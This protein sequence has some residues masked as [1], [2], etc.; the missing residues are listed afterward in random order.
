MQKDL[1]WLDLSTQSDFDQQNQILSADLT[2]IDCKNIASV[3]IY[4]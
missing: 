3:H 2:P 1:M 4:S